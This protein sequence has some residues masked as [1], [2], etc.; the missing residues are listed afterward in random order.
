[1]HR[2]A[3][4]V[5][6]VVGFV[7]AFLAITF[8]AGSAQTTAPLVVIALGTVIGALAIGCLLLGTRLLR[9][10]TR[11]AL[12]TSAG[13]AA[14]VVVLA[15]SAMALVIGSPERVGVA[16]LYGAIGALALVAGITS[17]SARNDYSGAR[18]PTGS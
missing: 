6:L 4:S 3:G 14:F 12:T 7:L 5:W 11:R 18:T 10:P 13:L 15:G 1:V 17:W 16:V 2:I 9:R 8:V